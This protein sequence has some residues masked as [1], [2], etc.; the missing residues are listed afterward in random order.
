MSAEVVRI[1]VPESSAGTRLDVFLA[2][3][4]AER[5]RS[6]ARRLVLEGCVIV[7]GRA[8][9]KP[10]VIVQRGMSV[11]VHLPPPPSPVPL[12]EPIPIEVVH[13]DDH[14]L[15]V[16]KPAGLVVH[17]GH[18]RSRG[19]LVNA[20]LGRG[21]RLAPAGGA[22]R[23][24][25]VH[26]L[27]RETSGLLV[28]AKTDEAHRALASAFARREVSKTY[29]ALVWRHP[30]PAE[31]TIE[32]AIGR[33]RSDPTRMS[34][35][36]PRGRPATTAYRILESLPGFALLEVRLV[37]GRTHQIRVHFQ[38]RQHP[39]VGDTRYGGQPWAGLRDATKRAAIRDFRRLA[40]HASELRFLHPATRR[41]IHLRS[42]LPPEFEALLA[43]LRRTE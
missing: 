31:G 37:T 2:A 7:D 5:T 39:V 12:P 41:E 33:S 24:G 22:D 29:L 25:I 11:E 32:Q 3:S 28:V 36:S 21:T 6:A 9:R 20:L 1:D 14:L 19:T 30:R 35:R 27:D 18:G 38:S 17:P 42:P 10:G 16:N 4:L 8:A 26:R 23:P 15:V 43:I 13:E 34:V 40:L